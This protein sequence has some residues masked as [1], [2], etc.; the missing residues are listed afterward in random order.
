[1]DR[2]DYNTLRRSQQQQNE[3]L[4]L[5]SP[6]AFSGIKMVKKALAIRLWLRCA[7]KLTALPQN[8]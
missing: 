7:W 6:D 5:F 1:M 4:N 3:E 2:T 8:P